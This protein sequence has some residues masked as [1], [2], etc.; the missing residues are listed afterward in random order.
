MADCWHLAPSYFFSYSSVRRISNIRRGMMANFNRRRILFASI[1]LCQADNSVPSLLHIY[2]LELPPKDIYMVFR[3]LSFV[4][5]SET[6]FV[7]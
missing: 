1:F 6:S 2:S 5:S 4:Y 3:G 7:L